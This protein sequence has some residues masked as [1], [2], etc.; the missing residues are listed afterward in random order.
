M[1]YLFKSIIILAVLV[2]FIGCENTTPPDSGE[3]RYIR[4]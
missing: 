4:K 2:L 1:T 3:G